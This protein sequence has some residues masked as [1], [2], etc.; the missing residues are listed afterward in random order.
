MIKFDEW[1][2]YLNKGEYPNKR[3][4]LELIEIGTGDPIAVATVNIPDQRMDSDEVAIKDYSEN[5][6]MLKALVNAQIIKLPHRYIDQ[7][8]V[9][10]PVCKLI[11]PTQ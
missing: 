10:I 8:F 9:T 6:G 7:G 4:A 3:I 5:E 2:C 1:R 11:T